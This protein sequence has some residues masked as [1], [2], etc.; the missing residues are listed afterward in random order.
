MKSLIILSL[1]LFSACQLAQKNSE[2]NEPAIVAMNENPTSL[3][4]GES[5]D[6]VPKSQIEKLKLGIILGPGG[7]RTIAQVGFLKRIQ[8]KRIP[9]AG[10]VGIEW[11]SVVGGL[12][13]QKISANEAEWQLSK[14]RKDKFTDQTEIKE[15]LEP[16][17]TYLQSS[18][19]ET[20]RL[21][22]ACPSLNIKKSQ[23]YFL[24][25]GRLD[26]LL[27]YCLAYP[28][29]SKVYDWSLAGVREVQRAAEFLRSR[30]A[31]R[32]IFINV[33]SGLPLQDPVNWHELT[34]DLKKKWVGVDHRLDIVIE[35]KS[36]RDYKMQTELVQLG[37]DQSAAIVEIL[38]K[39]SRENP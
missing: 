8:E 26:Q 18:K 14:I 7:G 36:I 20:G 19:A 12:Y 27:P 25:R 23:V 10:L 38:E 11:G 39:A 6:P 5:T 3:P 31:N 24:A 1:F 9:V 13:S 30:G 4:V 29:V 16:L 33:L 34:Y 22:F 35:Q 15:M 2:S 32:V 37:Y 17:E 28:P 21:I